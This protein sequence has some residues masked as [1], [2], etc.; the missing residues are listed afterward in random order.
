[1][2]LG[3]FAKTFE[4]HDPGTVLAAVQAAGYSATQYNL[5]CSGLPAMPDAIAPEAAQAVA[6]AAHA[7]G[8]SL[9]AV[10]GTYNMVHPDMAVRA[11]GH[12]RLEVLAA[13]CT[14]MG[15]RLIT[16]CTGTRDPFDQWREHPDNATPAAWRDLLAAM[17]VALDIAERH[18]VLLGIEPELANVV[19]SA[20][21]ARA[22]I[23]QLGSPR[24][25]I[26]LDAA[27]LFEA[28]SLE[29]QRRTVSEA[30][31]PVDSRMISG[32]STASMTS[33]ARA[34]RSIRARTAWTRA[35]RST[36]SSTTAVRSILSSTAS[37][38]AS[39]ATTAG[40]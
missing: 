34:T 29:T 25:R 40:T 28:V 5:A 31:E 33:S 21:K 20:A 7:H 30:I 24:L 1:M 19:S 35:S 8:L 23:A 6:R 37:S 11:A 16:L 32:R 3:L 39:K 14:G 9:T 36:R 12:A 38:T 27:N 2:Q 13:A 22:L 4:G 17:E 18:D 15:T 10:S 26:V